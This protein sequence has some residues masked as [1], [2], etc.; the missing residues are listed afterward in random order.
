MKV[1]CEICKKRIEEGGMLWA[2]DEDINICTYCY[3]KEWKEGIGRLVMPLKGF[4]V[5][6]IDENCPLCGTGLKSGK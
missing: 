5:S 4:S 6:G 2:K 1:K 3:D